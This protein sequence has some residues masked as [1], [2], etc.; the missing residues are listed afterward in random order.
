MSEINHQIQVLN[1]QELD[2]VCGG[3]I[4]DRAKAVVD[5]VETAVT[6]A[7]NSIWYP[8]ESKFHPVDSCPQCFT[9]GGGARG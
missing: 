3:D 4:I 7:W 8:S 2:V 1:D 5:K 6:D 9:G